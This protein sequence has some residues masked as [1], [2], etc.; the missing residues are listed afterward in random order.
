MIGAIIEA[1]RTVMGPGPLDSCSEVDR[2]RTS[3]RLGTCRC[4]VL[5]QREA[6]PCLAMGM[7]GI[8]VFVVQACRVFLVM[9]VE[10]AKVCEWVR[11][12]S[13]ACRWFVS[14]FGWIGVGTARIGARCSS[15]VVVWDF[16]W[17]LAF[18][19][20]N[21]Q[22]AFAWASQISSHYRPPFRFAKGLGPTGGL[23]P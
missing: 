6:V 22:S 13:V 12:W 16:I 21:F 11:V 3:L 17:E 15:G 20:S 19:S 8:V 7:M 5:R 1:H 18:V 9:V 4:Q 10:L 23:P 2:L 14:A